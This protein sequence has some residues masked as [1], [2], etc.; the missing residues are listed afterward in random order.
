MLRLLF[1]LVFIFGQVEIIPQSST[2]KSASIIF[3]DGQLKS[4]PIR[5]VLPDFNMA[6][7][8]SIKLILFPSDESTIEKDPKTNGLLFNPVLAADNQTC[9]VEKNGEKIAATGTILIFNLKKIYIPLYQSGKRFLPIIAYYPKADSTNKISEKPKYIIAPA[10]VLIANQIGA[11]FVST[12]ICL[13]ILLIIFVL[14]KI[15][16]GSF[17]DLL[18]TFG[19]KTS[20]SL[21]QMALWTL[22]VG[23]I[24][25]TYGL[26]QVNIPDIPNSLI[27]LMGLSIVTSAIGLTQSNIYDDERKK[28][29]KAAAPDPNKKIGFADALKSLISV[30][31]D[32]KEYPSVAKAQFLFWT[33]I[34]IIIFVYKSLIEGLIWAVPEELVFLMGLSQTSYLIRKQQA[35]SS[36]RNLSG[37]QA[38]EGNI[39]PAT[40]GNV[41]AQTEN[42]NAPSSSVGS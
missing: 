32:G 12:V 23:V 9:F 4:K 11:L 19:C 30:E 24:V 33:L 39:T 37:T 20:L 7:I 22:A 16:G 40:T 2:L 10:R 42:K 21:T 36:E 18:F 25:L 34:T 38:A 29:N 3:A 35:I 15:G 27:W 5:V 31:I 28:T 26:M 41:A 8:D 1:L 17:I 6:K 14:I 13:L